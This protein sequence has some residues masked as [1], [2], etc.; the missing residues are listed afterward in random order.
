MNKFLNN[1]YLPELATVQEIIQETAN[2]RTL[3]VSSGR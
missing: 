1:P 3:R 2:I